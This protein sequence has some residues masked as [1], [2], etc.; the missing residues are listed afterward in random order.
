MGR[1]TACAALLLLSGAGVARGGDTVNLREK[2]GSLNL[3]AIPP[4][5]PQLFPAGTRAGPALPFM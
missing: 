5:S 4:A 1:A 2:A 3:T